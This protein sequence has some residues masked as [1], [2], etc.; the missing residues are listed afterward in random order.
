MNT[1]ALEETFSLCCFVFTVFC[2]TTD[3]D[4]LHIEESSRL[5]HLAQRLHQF[6]FIYRVHS[7]VD[8]FKQAVTGL[9]SELLHRHLTQQQV[10]KPENTTDTHD[11]TKRFES[12]ADVDFIH[13]EKL[14]NFPLITVIHSSATFLPVTHFTQHWYETVF[15]S[16]FSP[17]SLFLAAI[18]MF[19]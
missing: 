10:H 2:V 13:P 7:F 9:L 18:A 6:G 16:Q 11:M 15:A 1:A 8:D 17:K 4:L 12:H 5:Q 19:T 14:C 3:S